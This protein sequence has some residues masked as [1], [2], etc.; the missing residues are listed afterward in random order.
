[1]E[2]SKQE[3]L[4]LLQNPPAEARGE[5]RWWWFGC[6]VRE[7]ELVRELDAMREAGIGGVELQ[8]LYPVAADDLEKGIRN[9]QYLSPEYL[10][11]IRRAAELAKERGMS[12]DVTLGSSWPFGGPFVPEELSAPNVIPY[13]LDVE[14]PC[15]FSY[16]FTT[17]LYGECVGCVVG[18]MEQS[19]MVPESIR[20]ITDRIGEK[21]LFGWPW[22]MELKPVEIPAGSHKIVLFLSNEKRQR[23][24]KPLPGGDGLIMDHNRRDA[25]RHFLLHGGD[26][27][28]EAG[29]GLIR[30]FFC[31][32]IEVFGQNWT[33]ILYDE[34]RKRRGYALRPYLYALWGQVG[35]ITGRIRY[36][37]HKTLAELTV[38]NFFRELTEWCHE[39]GTTSHIQAH[40]TWGDILAAYGA[41]DIPE[42]ETFSEFDR[43]EVNT[44]HRR[45]ASSA[46]HLYGKKIISCESFTWLRTPRFLVTLENIKAAADSI[47]LDGMNRIVNHGYAYSPPEAGELG[48]PF[49]AS[50]QINHKNTWWKFYPAIGRYI[51][52]VS[53]FLQRGKT[54]APVAVYLP[55]A[56]VWAENPLSDIHMAMKLEEKITTASVDSI[57]KAGFWF[58]FVHDEAVRNWRRYP[59]YR[60][61]VLPECER[62]E[63]E[64]ARAFAEWARAGVLLICKGHPP[65]QSC[66][67]R[68]YE[69]NT[70]EVQRIFREL[71]QEGRC[72]T[73][74]DDAA[75]IRSLRES[76]PTD[77][78]I[79]RNPEQIGF[80]HQQEEGRDIYFL[81]N[82]SPEERLESLCF[83]E[84]TGGFLVLDPMRGCELPVRSVLQGEDTQVELCFA[85]FQSVLIVFDKAL[86]KISVTE[87]PREETTLLSL[88][89]DWTLSVPEKGFVYTGALQSWEQFPA[90]RYFS[91]T[92]IYTRKFTLTAEELCPEAEIL[93]ILEHLGEAAEVWLNGEKAGEILMRP[94]RLDI[95]PL[96]RKEENLL[97]LRVCNL[98][99]NRAIDP[100]SPG[101]LYPEPLIDRW[102]YDT[103]ALNRCRRE[104]LLPEKEKEK[105]KEP[106]P[107]GIWGEVRLV[108]RKPSSSAPRPESRRPVSR[109]DR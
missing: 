40:G 68:D 24:L 47:F 76:V 64:T 35:E 18:R 7:E 8:I 32:S 11:W 102:P 63:P 106:L 43:Y 108:I 86:E 52:R 109:Q 101:E 15:T 107:S 78:E 3:L 12:L 46:G 36:D 13:T 85:P 56:D 55:Q 27:V 97:E 90:L 37:F 26:P 82:I 73:V 10:G 25:L 9:C 84:K 104:R 77:V 33:D 20:D 75:V 92:G 6:A 29:G 48:W 5:T 49:Y 58:D 2:Q 66:G 71:Q 91:G 45:L 100:D 44:I 38:E 93:L 65:R 4:Q 22:G 23:V 17:H 57:Q 105:V 72:V 34:F 60:A 39:K 67:M 96:L 95:T 89:G 21:K 87:L 79:R 69:N 98:L 53:A 59:G 80:L 14:G 99:I 54:V 1:M 19:R 41:A 31:D 42:G 30:S 51:Q 16:D 28:A 103:A 70:A 50:S 74:P 83:R 88:A 94:W 61:V 81:S 62:I